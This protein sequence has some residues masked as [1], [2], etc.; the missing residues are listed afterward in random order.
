MFVYRY[1]SMAKSFVT[2]LLNCCFIVFIFKYT[3][4]FGLKAK[5]VHVINKL[6]VFIFSIY[7]LNCGL[8]LIC[9]PEVG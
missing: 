2:C 9:E 7:C 1:V 3:N 4:G 5:T 8:V 6:I